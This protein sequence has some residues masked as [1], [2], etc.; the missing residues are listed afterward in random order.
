LT[1]LECYQILG[2]RPGASAEQIHRAYKQL[3]LLHHPDRS[4]GNAESH[5]I[6][7]QVTAAYS[8]LRAS[9]HAQAQLRNVGLCAKCDEV[10]ELFQGMDRRQY[11]AT[12]LLYS[13]RRYLP[14][15]TFHRIRC[16]AAIAF[17]S[18][19]LYCVI[20]STITGDWL[21]GAAAVLFVVAAMGALAFNFFTADVI[22]P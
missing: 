4:A 2:L 17:Q 6:F 5:K 8:R 1:Y 14:L 3:A 15:P 18:L 19:A 20:V 12:C 10:A 16:L 7:C 9:L 22:E 13:R 11:C 21:P